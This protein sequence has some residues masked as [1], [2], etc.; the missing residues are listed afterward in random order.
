[1]DIAPTGADSA[2]HRSRVVAA[3]AIVALCAS[4]S[5]Q[6]PA[7]H[8]PQET[9]AT[10]ADTRWDRD[11]ID[12]FV[13]QQRERTLVEC[14]NRGVSLPEDFLAWT[15]SDPLLERSIYGCRK[16]PLAVLLALRSLEIDLGEDIVRREYPELALAFAIQSSYRIPSRKAS[17]WNDGDDGGPS[18]RSLPDLTP[19]ARLE[20]VVPGDPRVRVDTK[21]KDRALD[22]D[23]H[24]INFLEDHA[25]I[26]VDVTTKELPPLEYDD[27]GVAKPRGKAVAVTKQVERGLLAADVIADPRLQAEFNAY[28]AEHGHP[29]VAIDC[30]DHAV[31]WNSRDAIKDA[32]L[33]SRIAAAH[34]LFHRAYRNKGRMPAERDRAPTMAESMAWFVRNDRLALSEAQQQAMKTARVPLDA[35]WPI[36]IMLAADDQPLREREDIWQQFRERASFRTYGEYIGGIAQQFD[37][38]SAR[39]TSPLAYS[40]GSIQMMWKDGGVCGT[41]GNIGARTYRIVGVP[42]STAGQPGHCAI[43]RMEYEPASRSYRCVGGQYATG[44]DEVT[45]VH[46]GWNFDDVGGRRPMVFWQTV[47]LSVSR[48]FAAFLDGLVRR[49]MWDAADADSRAREGTSLLRAALADDP[50]ALPAVLGA[51]DGAVDADAARQIGEVFASAVPDTKEL[52][53]YRQ[54]VKDLVHQRLLALPAPPTVD[55]AKELA[56]ILDREGCRNA[57]LLARTWRQVGGD[58]EF[59]ARTTD[60]VR[61]Y[62]RSKERTANKNT[63]ADFARLLQGLERAVTGKSKRRSWASAML[64]EFN[65]HESLRLGK[66][67]KLDPAVV[68]LCKIT[69][70]APPAIE[71][72]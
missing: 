70:Q 44:G 72:H 38:Q 49:R 42:A 6:Q 4:V 51:L 35:P 40:Y 17:N 62:V 33:R 58:A 53:L 66:K 24:I 26:T 30:G 2:S 43:V 52:Q 48:D 7:R 41:M 69:G 10:V 22:I 21:A 3:F 1:M 55:T 57:A 27:Q 5:S 60:L 12:R 32:A 36:L 67:V 54:T 9:V 34:E 61:R 18:D 59:L 68:L 23:D 28:L 65:G 71:K 19:R 31:H 46:A 39:R 16:D 14:K 25:P 37:M 20:L 50:F 15:A 64:A 13:R 45:T 63:S 56:A 11:D 47:A 29:D 8:Q